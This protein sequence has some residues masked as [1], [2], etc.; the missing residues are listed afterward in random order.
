ML[1]EKFHFSDPK[2]GLFCALCAELLHCLQHGLFQYAIQLVFEQ[3]KQKKPTMQ[4]TK[5]LLIDV[6]LAI[7]I[8][9]NLSV[10]YES[11]ESCFYIKVIGIYLEQI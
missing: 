8:V 11:M 5:S 1:G 2:R 4:L 10:Y 6:F 9:S 3:K 7:H